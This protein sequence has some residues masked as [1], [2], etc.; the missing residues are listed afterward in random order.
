MKAKS[1]G[2][3]PAAALRHLIIVLGDQLDRRAAAFDGFDPAQD[4]VWMAEVAEESTHVP[5]AKQRT[6]LFLARCATSPQACATAAAAAL[7]PAGRRRQPGTLAAELTA[8]PCS[9]TAP[10]APGDDR[11]GRLARAAG[12]ARRGRARRPAAG[13][14]RGPPLLRSRA[15]VRR[16][17]Q[18]PQAAA[19]GVL[20]P[21]AAPPPRRADGRRPTSP[22]AA[23]GTS[24]PTTARPSAQRPAAVPAP[25]RFPPDA[26]TRDVLTS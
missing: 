24:T 3:P 11:P 8:R 5:S 19:A 23:P 9:A 20:V 4:A 22:P 14:A 16:P 12:P 7:P 2:E 1:S 25:P 21:R 13:P 17:R 18:G 26:V 15:R 10:A 6:A